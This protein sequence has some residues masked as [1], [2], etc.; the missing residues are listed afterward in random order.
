MIVDILVMKRACEEQELVKRTD[1]PLCAWTL[2]EAQG[3]QHCPFCGWQS[4]IVIRGI[5]KNE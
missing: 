2:E 5:R 1:C 3:I 4:S